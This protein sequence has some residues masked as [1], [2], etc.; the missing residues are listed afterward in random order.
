MDGGKC[1]VSLE[2][3]G[4]GKSTLLLCVA[5]FE[6]FGLRRNPTRR[7]VVSSAE[8]GSFT[9][10]ED[11][12]VAMVLE[13]GGVAAY[14]GIPKNG[15]PIT[16]SQRKALLVQPSQKQSSKRIPRPN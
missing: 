12:E 3:S 9:A 4:C 6:P 11:R 16:R 1:F 8:N 5:G 14:T 2:P 15:F 10:P 7:S 13:L